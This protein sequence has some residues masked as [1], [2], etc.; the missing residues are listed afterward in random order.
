MFV[1]AHF[2]GNQVQFDE[3]VNLKPD[4]KVWVQIP[5]DDKSFEEERREWFKFSLA[6]FAR[7]YEDE[8]DIYTDDM[9][10]KRNPHYRGN[11]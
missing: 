10:I 2:D 5:D 9:I 7:L 8:P 4:T 1:A 11:I 6:N 3:P